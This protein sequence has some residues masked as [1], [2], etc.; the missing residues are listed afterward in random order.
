MTRAILNPMQLIRH[1]DRTRTPPGQGL[2]PLFRTISGPPSG[3]ELVPEVGPILDRQVAQNW[4]HNLVQFL[5]TKWSR[6]GARFWLNS[7]PPGG[8]ILSHQM[9]RNWCQITEQKLV[10]LLSK[11]RARP[12]ADQGHHRGWLRWVTKELR[13]KWRPSLSGDLGRPAV[14]P[15]LWTAI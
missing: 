15:W 2:M 9:T 1:C 12:P 10:R 4:Y 6:I 8:P 3:P 14:W 7:G 5:T 11:A 13:T